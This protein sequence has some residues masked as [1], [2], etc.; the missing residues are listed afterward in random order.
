MLPSLPMRWQKSLFS[1]GLL[2]GPGNTHPPRNRRAGAPA[3]VFWSLG[4]WSER[5]VDASSGA[6]WA[7]GWAPGPERC[8]TGG[9][10]GRRYRQQTGCMQLWLRPACPALPL[11]R[12][13]ARGPPLPACLCSG[14]FV[15]HQLPPGPHPRPP[16]ALWAG[17]V[18]TAWAGAGT[19]VLTHT[20]RHG[21]HGAFKQ[22]SPPPHR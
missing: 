11:V 10:G 16:Q 4:P 12:S 6:R 1:C 9:Q 7:V 13:H 21:P 5:A 18:G 15:S 8:F 3:L 17:A 20:W 14:D 2:Q 22:V 19:D